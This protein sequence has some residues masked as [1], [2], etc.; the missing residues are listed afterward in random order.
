MNNDFN[1]EK[2]AM[3][4]ETES[5]LFYRSRMGTKHNLCIIEVL[6]KEGASL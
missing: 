4:L 5:G 1:F 2:S 3:L 6:P